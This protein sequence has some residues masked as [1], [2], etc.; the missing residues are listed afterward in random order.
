MTDDDINLLLHKVEAL[1]RSQ[2]VIELTLDG[3]VI[4]ANERFLH[5]MGYSEREVIGHQHSIFVLT[6]ESK[7]REYDELWKRLRNG[8]FT[9][10]EFCRITKSGEKVWIHGVYCPLLDDRGSPYRIIKFAADVTEARRRDA[11]FVGQIAAIRR[12]QAFI[13]FSL[14]GIVTDANDKFLDIM[15]Y[16][17][18]Q[19]RGRHH[20]L[21]VMP[22]ERDTIAYAAF[23]LRLRD[24]NY[25]SGLF[26]R[27]DSLGRVRWIQA[28]YNPV[29]DEN[30]KL[31]K[32]VKFAT[33]QTAAIEDHRRVEY[34]YRH[35]TLTGLANRAGLQMAIESALSSGSA[36]TM[37]LLDLDLF[38]SINDSFGHPAGDFCLTVVA[39]RIKAAAPNAT[40]VARLGG[41]EFAIVLP[42][43]DEAE[44]TA[45]RIVELVGKPFMW[46]GVR[47]TV[48]ASVGIAPKG[49]SSSS[50]LRK[51]DIALYAAKNAG[52]NT[53]RLFAPGIEPDQGDHNVDAPSLQPV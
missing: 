29:S 52:R 31:T 19:I 16:R 46:E 20:S 35:D 10:G 49:H 24:G 17:L 6:E 33:D 43:P 5:L 25:H 39:E 9:V 26:K 3:T 37:L 42:G 32:V 18:A 40:V 21:F 45:A 8:E 38:K 34:L 28:S 47:L 30:G 15:G 23:W 44:A 27:I 50:L 48:G 14:D 53:Y 11:D 4:R 13:E 1:E 41:D 22:N 2:A 7:T 36:P 51:A 12:S